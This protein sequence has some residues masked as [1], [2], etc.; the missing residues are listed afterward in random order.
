MGNVD[1]IPEN[2]NSSQVVNL[3]HFKVIKTI[4]QGAFGK[5][6]KV[7][8]TQRRELYALKVIVKEKCIK[9]DAVS[10]VIRERTILER[11]DH[12]LICNMRFAFQDDFTMFMAM[13]Y[14][15]GGDLRSHL[16]ERLHDEMTIKFWM[17]E[18]ICAVKYLHS[19][20]IVHRDI[21]P[22]NI[23]LDGEGHIHLSDFNIACQIPKNNEKKLSSLSGTAVYFAPEMFLGVGYNEDVDWWSVGITFYECIYGERPW[24][25]CTDIDELGK[26]IVHKKIPYP[27]HRRS[28]SNECVSAIKSFL[29]INP[30]KR[31]GHG[32][33]SGWNK[34]ASHSFFRAID[35]YSIDNKQCQPVYTPHIESIQMNTT[36]FH[37][38]KHTQSSQHGEQDHILAMLN[39]ELSTTPTT[40]HQNEGVMGWLYR[41]KEKRSSRTQNRQSQDMIL[42]Q[43]NFKSFD[44]TIFDQYEGFLDQHL[45]TVGPPPDWVKPAFP[46]ADNGGI[47]ISVI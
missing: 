19:Q 11:V 30:N 35:W 41:Q 45:M 25:Y 4:G 12:P 46:G 5:V 31:L 14:M 37:S 8:H 27:T 44:Y 17:A 6:F 16:T 15:S 3:T 24:S 26:Q 28:I 23:L 21:K 10:N 18:L 22:D 1:S 7:Q 33:K 20:G 13:D 47:H 9:M 38:Q 34:I 39:D 29:Q 36:S 2:Y 43:H 40:A 32:I 42:L